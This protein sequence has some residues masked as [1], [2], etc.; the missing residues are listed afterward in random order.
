MFIKRIWY[1]YINFVRNLHGWIWMNIC[2]V[3]I[4][5]IKK[6]HLLFAIFFLLTEKISIEIVPNFEKKCKN[7][8]KP[9]CKSSIKIHWKLKEI[10]IYLVKKNCLCTYGWQNF[11]FNH[12]PHTTT[13]G[14]LLKY[15]KQMHKKLKKITWD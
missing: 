6:W 1:F 10:W 5:L 11:F 3:I 7:I 14:N 9:L 4:F 2:R 15:C 12:I 13:Q 8:C